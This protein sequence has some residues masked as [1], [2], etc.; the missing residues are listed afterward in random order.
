VTFWIFQEGPAH[1]SPFG[2]LEQR[3]RLIECCTRP[4]NFSSLLYYCGRISWLQTQCPTCSSKARRVIPFW[5]IRQPSHFCFKFDSWAVQSVA[6]CL[7]VRQVSLG[8][9]SLVHPYSLKTCFKSRWQ[10][11][12]F[13]QRYASRSRQSCGK[14]LLASTRCRRQGPTQAF[15]RRP[16]WSLSHWARYSRSWYWASPRRYFPSSST[17]WWSHQQVVQSPLEPSLPKPSCLSVGKR[18]KHHQQTQSNWSVMHQPDT[19]VKR[20]TR[21]APPSWCPWC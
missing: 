16:E 18:Y 8:S 17:L 6:W 1:F 9:L 4:R 11:V 13:Q 10:S 14:F 15:Y 3:S 21:H 7:V 5:I 20:T 19:C 2:V 12:S